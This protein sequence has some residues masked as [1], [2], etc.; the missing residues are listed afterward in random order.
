MLHGGSLFL[1]GAI[2]VCRSPTRLV[3][4]T[5]RVRLL[6]ETPG[7]MP[8]DHQQDAPNLEDLIQREREAA[9]QEREKAVE[10][11]AW[12]RACLMLVSGV[13]IVASLLA[14]IL[15][16]IQGRVLILGVVALVGFLRLGLY[17]IRSF[18]ADRS[19]AP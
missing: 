17:A 7:A 13:S 2:H 16:L 18:T 12:I 8:S 11:A 15:L 14:A 3:R 9:W 6:R 1:Y 19:P 10:A 5:S 4:G